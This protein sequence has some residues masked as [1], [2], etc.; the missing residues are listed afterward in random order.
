MNLSDLLSEISFVNT[1]R[2]QIFC[3]PSDQARLTEDAHVIFDEY[4]LEFT[5]YPCAV[6][7][8]REFDNIPA[9]RV[10]LRPEHPLVILFGVSGSP[11]QLVIPDNLDA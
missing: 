10:R 9:K 5:V 1:E 2:V 4:D 8:L 6:A 3:I 7:N 11:T